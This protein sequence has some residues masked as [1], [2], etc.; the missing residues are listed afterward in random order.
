[1]VSKVTTKQVTGKSE[2]GATIFIKKGD[3][4]IGKEGVDK[5][6]NFTVKIDKQ[7]KGTKVEIIARDKAGN[8]S[9]TS[10]TVK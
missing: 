6:G 5:K 8:V 7:K 3:K 2:K 10:K 9:K 1:M 4:Q